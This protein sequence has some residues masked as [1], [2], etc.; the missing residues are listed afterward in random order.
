MLRK[1]RGGELYFGCC[2]GIEQ[3]RCIVAFVIQMFLVKRVFKLVV[4]LWALREGEGMNTRRR[5]CT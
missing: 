5:D 3:K 4:M 2:W 1:G